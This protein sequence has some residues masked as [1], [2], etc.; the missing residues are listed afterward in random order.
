MT[1]RGLPKSIEWIGGT[2]GHVRI[3]DQTR[4]PSELIFIEC[5]DAA[6]IREAIKQLR[7]RGA[8]LIGIAA[9]MGAVL[10]VRDYRGGD[11]DGYLKHLD[12]VC[13][14]LAT[15]RPTAVNLFWALERMKRYARSVKTED[16]IVLKTALLDEAL[17][18]RE[19]DA[20]SCGEIGRHGQS[21]INPGAG[22]L[23]YCNAGVLATAELGTALAPIYVA[24][25]AGRPFRVYASE[26]RPLLQGSRLTAW[27]LQQ[28]GVD[29]T[30]VCDNMVGVLMRQGKINLVI[31]GADRI[32]ANGDVANKIGTYSVA[33]LA[34]AHSIPFYV[35]APSSTFDLAVSDGAAIPIEE[36][37][38]D[39]IR[40]VFGRLTAPPDIPCFCP[41]FD[42]TPAGLVDGIITDQ[43]LIQPVNPM[44]IMQAIGC[45]TFDEA[46]CRDSCPGRE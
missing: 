18:I 15:S 32:A 6:A 17:R 23:T 24:H 13:A 41:A 22:V 19:E 46:T 40:C 5:R 37:D 1:V 25:E 14:Y 30:V 7:V 45:T 36:R 8:P 12:D 42:V 11:R 33:V 16:V 35:A 27:E 2:D 43:G 39:E 29:V 26:T 28:A 21:L 4:L 31:T 9:A 3:I 34:R 44:R 38:A 10:G 20:A